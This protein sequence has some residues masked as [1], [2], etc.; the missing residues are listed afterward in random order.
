MLKIKVGDKVIVLSGQ[1]KGV[2]G[3]VI[4]ILPK[5]NK[6]IVKGINCKSMGGVGQESPIYL[7]K[8]ALIDPING[9]PTRIGFEFKNGIK[10]RI[11][12]RSGTELKKNLK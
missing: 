4:R 6:A 10:H 2:K 7:N 5:D 11:A 8:I 9:K 12:K 3:K 1:Y